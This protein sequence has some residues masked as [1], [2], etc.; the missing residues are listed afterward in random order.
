[1]KGPGR[2]Y[3]EV[4]T[5]T[6]LSHLLKTETIRNLIGA[7]DLESL[8]AYLLKTGYADEISKIIHNPEPATLERTFYR[9][10][11][12]RYEKYGMIV[13]T[14][15]I[16]DSLRNMIKNYMAR[17]EVENLKRI[18][19]AVHSNR[20][21][22]EE[23]LIPVTRRISH[24]NFKVMVGAKT[25]DEF[26]SLLKETAYS[27]I[28]NYLS[29][30]FKYKTPIIF[31]SK[32]D[33]FY[34]V[35]VWNEALRVRD[36]KHVKEILGTEIDLRNIWYILQLAYQGASKEL[37]Y[38]ALMR[39]SYEIDIKRLGKT[40]KENSYD[41]AV[42]ELKRS[43]YS[44]IVNEMYELIKKGKPDHS[45]GILLKELR[46]VCLENL[47][48]VGI[49]IAYLLLAYLESV[50]LTTIGIGKYLKVGKKD[51]SSYV[52]I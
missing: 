21:I 7:E 31:E 9:K 52:S 29:V 22:T 20:T 19:R 33:E 23:D 41:A 1:M 45:Y 18:V 46:R 2:V 47:R 8:L 49:P 17:L 37:G 30:Y 38:E 42:S 36:S 15:A 12:E 43:K 13:D 25:V 6:L 3:L 16:R 39:C 40:L 24:I 27:R 48:G 50:D 32:L 51:V 5:K 4:R 35:R 26:V 11:V 14:T 44:R 10:V 34:Y 28:N